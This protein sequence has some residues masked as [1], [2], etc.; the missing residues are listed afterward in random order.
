MSLKFTKNSYRSH[1]KLAES[2]RSEKSVQR[3]KGKAPEPKREK[4]KQGEN[5]IFPKYRPHIHSLISRPP[6]RTHAQTK[7][8]TIS[9]LGC[10]GALTPPTSDIYIYIYIYIYISAGPF[11]GHQAARHINY[12]VSSVLCILSSCILAFTSF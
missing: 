11:R 5:G 1:R 6:A 10:A 12:P 7:T 9:R 2:T 8:K 3:E 4:G